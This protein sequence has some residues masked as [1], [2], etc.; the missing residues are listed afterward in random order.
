MTFILCNVKVGIFNL[1]VEPHGCFHCLYHLEFGAL[2]T[3]WITVKSKL[4]CRS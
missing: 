4:R 3:D 2:E 1:S